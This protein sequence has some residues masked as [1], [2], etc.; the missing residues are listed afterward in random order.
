MYVV[1]CAWLLLCSVPAGH[2]HTQHWGVRGMHV[3]VDLVRSPSAWGACVRHSAVAPPPLCPITRRTPAQLVATVAPRP[4]HGKGWVSFLSDPSLWIACTSL[5]PHSSPPTCVNLSFNGSSPG[6]T[7]L[8]V[9]VLP[10]REQPTGVPAPERLGSGD[11]HPTP[12]GGLG[13]SLG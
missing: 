10:C 5:P 12:G 8:P 1:H 6:Q 9:A 4:T 7:I 2:L 13:A 11:F 3:W